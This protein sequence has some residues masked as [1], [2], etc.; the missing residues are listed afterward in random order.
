MKYIQINLQNEFQRHIDNVVQHWDDNNL[1]T[2]EALI[3]DGKAEQFGVIQVVEASAPDY[4]PMTQA[5][6]SEFAAVAGVWTQ[7]WRIH[8]LDSQAIADKKF[9]RDQLRYTRR[10]AVRDELMAYMAADNMRR[11]RAATWAVADLASLTTDPAV[12]A[13]TAYMNTL[14]YEL[15]AQAIQSA[16]NPILT[17]EIKAEWIAKLQDHFYLES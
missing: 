16:T 9:Q 10:A 3:K 7:I 15:A 5:V 1:C 6:T 8:D 11:V 2:P 17:T 14:S 4:D 13:A 12:A